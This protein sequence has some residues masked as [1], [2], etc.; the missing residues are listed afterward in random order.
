MNRFKVF[1]G[2]FK[3]VKNTPHHPELTEYLSKNEHFQKACHKVHDFQYYLLRKLDEAAF[4]E[5]YQ[6][7]KLITKGQDKSGTK[8]K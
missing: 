6:D 7:Q 4:P 2:I 5:N 1:F 8:K 3:E